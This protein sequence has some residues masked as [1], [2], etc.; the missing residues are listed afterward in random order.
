MPILTHSKMKVSMNH[1][2][3]QSINQSIS[4]S[5]IQSLGG[6][7]RSSG[8]SAACVSIVGDGLSVD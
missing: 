5:V 4:Q 8:R 2:M 1:L 7:P 3:S 6:L